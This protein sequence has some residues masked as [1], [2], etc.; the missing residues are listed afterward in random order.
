MTEKDFIKVFLPLSEAI[1]RV[2][3]YIPEDEEDAKDTVQEVFLKLWKSR[4][5]LDGILNPKAYALSMARNLCID[6]MRAARTVSLEEDPSLEKGEAPSPYEI[7]SE[8]ERLD[9]ILAAVK[10]LPDKQ[11]QVLKLRTMDG[12]TYDEISK[13]T[14]ISGLSARVLLSRAR[15]TLKKQRK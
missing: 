2:A 9:G 5:S 8:K 4:P 10:S 1:Y 6:R 12:L 13:E 3:F 14:G 11:R 15:S 7:L